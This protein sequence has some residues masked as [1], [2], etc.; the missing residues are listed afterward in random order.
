MTYQ[1]TK[2]IARALEERD[3]RYKVE[4]TEKSSYVEVSFKG[5][6]IR[7]I[8]IKLISSDDDNDVSVRSYAI[9]SV[10]DEKKAAIL[11][12]VNEINLKYR[13]L[14]FVLDEDGDVNAEY[15]IPQKTVEIGDVGYELVSRFVNIIDKAYPMFM[16]ALWS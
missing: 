1:A 16:R 5:D 6:N 3:I 11:A 14:K 9:V 4:E 10:P 7:G 13:Y 8:N 15:D 2:K 12:I